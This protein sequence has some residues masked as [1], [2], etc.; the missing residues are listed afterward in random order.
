MKRKEL[1]ATSLFLGVLL[2]ILNRVALYF[3]LF[4]TIWWL[5]LAFHFVGGFAVGSLVIGLLV[6]R[7]NTFWVSV[8][9]VFILTLLVALFWEL[10]ELFFHNTVLDGYFIDSVTDVMLGLAGGLVALY[11]VPRNLWK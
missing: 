1:L 11:F 4:W 6:S 9:R 2:F 3:K 10:Y 7:E 8:K 5:D